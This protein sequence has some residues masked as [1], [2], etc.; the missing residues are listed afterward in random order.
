MH[1][2]FNEGKFIFRISDLEISI[3]SSSRANKS[4]NPRLE[5]PEVIGLRKE[6]CISTASPTQSQPA[7]LIPLGVETQARWVEV[8]KSLKELVGMSLGRNSKTGQFQFHEERDHNPEERGPPPGLVSD[9][10]ETASE[11]SSDPTISLPIPINENPGYT[12]QYTL[13]M[14]GII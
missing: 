13:R 4:K 7:T 14:L 3:R 1:H 10:D 8:P 12:V 9:D 6:S 11:A 5:S 2:E